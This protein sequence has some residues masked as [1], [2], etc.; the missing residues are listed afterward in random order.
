[1]KFLTNKQIGALYAISSGFL[2]GFLGYFGISIVQAGCSVENMLLWRFIISGLFI[3]AIMLYTKKSFHEDY[4][5]MIKAIFYGIAFYG[6]SSAIWFFSSIYIGTGLSMVIFFTYPAIVI[7]FNWILYREKIPKLYYLAISIIIF[8][9]IL[10]VDI[11][12]LSFDLKGILLGVLSAVFYACY[13]IASKGNKKNTR[14]TPLI[15]TLMVSIGCSITSLIFTI[16]DNSF[17]VPSSLNM[18][19]NIICVA[20]ISTAIPIFLLLE[21]FKYLTAEEGSILSVTEP[22]FVVLFGILLLGEHI[23]LT[24]IIGVATILSGALITIFAKEKK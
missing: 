24:Q 23:T 7:I 21:A 5:E 2:Y 6:T 1:M 10:L 4:Y 13:M 17:M 15:S 3:F 22:V 14:I 9:M 20:T 11:H 8:G 18:W 19:W 16:F 12:E